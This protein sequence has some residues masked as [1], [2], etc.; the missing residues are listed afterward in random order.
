[1]N[2]DRGSKFSI[3]GSVSEIGKPNYH[4]FHMPLLLKGLYIMIMYV[5]EANGSD[6]RFLRLPQTGAA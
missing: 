5:E 6:I 3:V 1:M 2:M 4:R